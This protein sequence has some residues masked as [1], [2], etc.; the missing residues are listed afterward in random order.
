MSPNIKNVD[1]IKN[2]N[3]NVDVPHEGAMC[4]LL[5]S[6]PDDNKRGFSPSPRAAGYLFGQDI[7]DTF[8][9][10]NGLTTIARAHQLVMDGYS[11]HHSKKVVTIF[12]A[13]NYCYRCGNQAAVME[14]DEQ[15]NQNYTQYNQA[16][17]TPE[18]ATVKRPPQYFL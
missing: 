18:P 16:N 11:K 14:I 9:H 5:W 12:S 10:Q 3:R 8:L 4:D 2:L 15:M 13:P 17:D 7:T 1:D 6:D